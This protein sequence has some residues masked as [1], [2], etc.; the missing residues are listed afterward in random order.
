MATGEVEV[1]L[2]FPSS[3]ARAEFLNR[4]KDAS[5]ANFRL[6]PLFAQP[7]IVVVRAIGGLTDQRL[8]SELL[9]HLDADVKIFDDVQ[10]KVM[11]PSAS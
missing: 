1:I 4:M 10:F 7:D 2:K 8:K 6:K 9:Q 3:G 5:V 11:A